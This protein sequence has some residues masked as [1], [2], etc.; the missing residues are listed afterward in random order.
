MNQRFHKASFLNGLV[1]DHLENDTFGKAAYSITKLYPYV[2][3]PL[4]NRLS[5]PL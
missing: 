3:K 1:S 4:K 5:V 2:E